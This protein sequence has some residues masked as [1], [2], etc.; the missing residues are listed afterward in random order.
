MENPANEQLNTQEVN[1]SEFAQKEPL[2][3][4]KTIK[5]YAMIAVSGLLG[6]AIIITAVVIYMRFMDRFNVTEPTPPVTPTPTPEIP[7]AASPLIAYI[8]ND[9]SI[10]IVNTDGTDKKVLLELP[11]SSDQFFSDLTWKSKGFLSYSLCD[12]NPNCTVETYNLETKSSVTEINNS[13]EGFVESL[14]WAPENKFIGY[15]QYKDQ[16]SQNQTVELRLKTGTTNTVLSTHKTEIKDIEQVSKVTFS[17]DEDHIAFG[18]VELV[19]STR[20][21]T[22]TYTAKPKILVYRVSGV[23]LDTISDAKDPMFIDEKT[24]EYQK[25]AQLIHREIGTLSETAITPITGFNLDVSP[26]KSKY[27]YWSPTGGFSDALLII[28]DGNLNLQRNILR[29]V[30]FPQWISNSTVVGIKADNCLGSKCELFDYQ[31][32]SLATVNIETKQANPIDQGRTIK[33]VEVNYYAN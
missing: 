16:G 23:L 24:I 25:G 4:K 26:D 6:L 3:Y 14:T 1:N 20:G 11:G 30:L 32:I 8:K 15:F 9:K 21:R 33:D 10:W 22:I 17:E 27:A 12:T 2:V 18:F 31:T 13:E 28:F 5:K 29:G 7:K 19:A